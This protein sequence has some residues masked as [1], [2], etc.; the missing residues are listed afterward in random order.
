MIEA[1]SVMKCSDFHVGVC[2]TGCHEEGWT[3]R[4]YP[5]SIYSVQYKTGKMPDLGLGISGDICCGKFE[6]VKRLP[7][8]WWIRRYGQKQGFNDADIAAIVAATPQNFLKLCGEIASKYWRASH[9]DIQVA[10][11]QAARKS[12]RAARDTGCPGCGSKW[13]SIICNNCGY[14][15]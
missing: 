2:C 14:D 12:V 4:V 1:P 13:D 11:P 6:A 7:R 10:R 5:E 8:E 3:I 9:P 15:G